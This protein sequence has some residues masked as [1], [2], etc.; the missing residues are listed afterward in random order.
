[1]GKRKSSLGIGGCIIPIIG[2]V[3][4]TFLLLLESGIL[5]FLFLGIAISFYFFNKYNESKSKPEIKS[6]L[7]E[8]ELKQRPEIQTKKINEKIIV[9]DD[10]VF[11][12]NLVFDLDDNSTFKI[13]ITSSGQTEI[14][15]RLFYNK[16]F[17]TSHI[18]K[19]GFKNYKDAI[20]YLRENND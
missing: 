5:F 16:N 6:D 12:E 20:N 13:S 18:K 1:M 8:S 14:Y 11:L 7:L 15:G 2:V 4:G 9:L 10:I 19:G 17:K 3:F